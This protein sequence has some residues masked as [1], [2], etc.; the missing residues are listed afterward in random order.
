MKLLLEMTRLR[1]ALWRV[2]VT[3]AGAPLDVSGGTFTF[4]AKTTIAGSPL[5]SKTSG[6]GITVEDGPGG[7]LLVEVGPDDTEGLANS[8]TVL[9]CELT[10]AFGG[11]VYSLARGRLTVFPNIA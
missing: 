7:I 8:T 6:A 3:A 10:G 11:Q 2:A 9:Q 4:A 1:T 5:F